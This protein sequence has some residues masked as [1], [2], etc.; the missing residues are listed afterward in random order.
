MWYMDYANDHHCPK[1][2]IYGHFSL[3]KKEYCY[4]SWSTF[5]DTKQTDKPTNNKTHNCY[6][7]I[8]SLRKEISNLL[9]AHLSNFIF[10]WRE[11]E[12]T[13][14]AEISSKSSQ[15]VARV[16]V[17]TIHT[18]STIATSVINAVV[19]V[20]KL[21]YDTDTYARITQVTIKV[22]GT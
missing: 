2:A 1:M 14:L 17:D 15:A 18:W 10:Y 12:L 22:V 20:W 13:S 16:F 19:D 9:S 8:A 3:V 7:Y 6:S 4:Q 5:L 11:K 21:G